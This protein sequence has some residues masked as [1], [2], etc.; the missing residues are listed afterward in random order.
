MNL[1]TDLGGIDE[2]KKLAKMVK[3]LIANDI[4]KAAFQLIQAYDLSF[5]SPPSWPIIALIHQALKALCSLFRTNRT[6]LKYQM[7]W[8]IMWCIKTVDSGLL[9][10]NIEDWIGPLN[11][12]NSPTLSNSTLPQ[13]RDIVIGE[14]REMVLS[15]L[16][17][18][19]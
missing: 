12:E 9:C 15:T 18:V 4:C 6:H 14:I 5:N 16:Y 10:W 11:S 19:I 8:F 2:D 1:Q 13:K 7:D 3:D 17:T